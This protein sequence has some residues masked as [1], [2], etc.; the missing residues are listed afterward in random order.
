MVGVTPTGDLEAAVEVLHDVLPAIKEQMRAYILDRIK[1]LPAS[2]DAAE[3]KTRCQERKKAIDLLMF[4]SLQM[5]SVIR[6]VVDRV[7][8]WEYAQMVAKAVLLLERVIPIDHKA[9]ANSMKKRAEDFVQ[10]SDLDGEDIA[11]IDAEVAKACRPLEQDVA[12]A[13][14]ELDKTG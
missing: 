4:S 8:G 14:E 11:M 1:A 2:T 12:G 5:I 10:E 7:N 3:E 6:C 13:S 9:G